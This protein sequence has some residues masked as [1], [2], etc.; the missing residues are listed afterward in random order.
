MVKMK[1]I[2]RNYVYWHNIDKNIEQFVR[3]CSGCALAAKTPTKTL[4]S[5][6]PITAKVF[7]RVHIDLAETQRGDYYFLLVDAFSKWPEI[8]R[9]S[10]ISSS[11]IIEILDQLFARFG[12]PNSIVSD[13]GRQFISSEFENYCSK[14]GITHLKTSP[15]SPMSNGQVERFVDT[16]KRSFEKMEGEGNMD[17]KL[18]AFLQCYRSSPNYLLSNQSSPAEVFLGR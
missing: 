15:F 5:S 9:T 12:Y 8:I 4:L 13:N 18:Q 7:E 3:E 1:Q 17:Q 6:W 10:S 2:A 16:F 11:K 14:H